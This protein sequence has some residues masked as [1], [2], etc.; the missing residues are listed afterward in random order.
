MGKWRFLSPPFPV[1]FI[2]LDLLVSTFPCFIYSSTTF[3]K[4]L[5]CLRRVG[6]ARGMFSRGP[7]NIAKV[8]FCNKEPTSGQFTREQAAYRGPVQTGSDR[9][10]QRTRWF[11]IW[12]F[13]VILKLAS[14]LTCPYLA[15]PCR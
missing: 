6:L 5:R 11:L 7:S 12:I 15:S 14:P 3:A 13:T 4:V 9:L 1:S 8:P 2:V 10:H